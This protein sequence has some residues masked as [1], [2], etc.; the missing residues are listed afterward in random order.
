MRL[1]WLYDDTN[2]SCKKNQEKD[3][4]LIENTS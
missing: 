4:I 3:I 2:T 1:I